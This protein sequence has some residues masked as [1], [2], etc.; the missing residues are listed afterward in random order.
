MKPTL[1]LIAAAT[2]FGTPALAQSVSVT[3][4]NLHG[5]ANAGNVHAGDARQAQR[6]CDTQ[7]VTVR[8]A[9]GSTSSSVSVSSSGGQTVV[10]GSGSPGSR[11][12][13]Y[14]CPPVKHAA[15]RHK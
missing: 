7:G 15:R 1:A 4:G 14:G 12:E 3:A 2:L 10:A 5:T 6:H 8:S 9:D 13:R 11:I